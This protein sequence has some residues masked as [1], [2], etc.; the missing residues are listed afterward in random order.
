[1]R[2]RLRAL[3]Q[4]RCGA[5]CGRQRQQRILAKLGIEP[6]PEPPPAPLSRLDLR[7]AK[8]RGPGEAFLDI[9][10]ELR[11]VLCDPAADAPLDLATLQDALVG[12]ALC[13]PAIGI[14]P[15]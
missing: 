14:L 13:Q 1:V 4:R 15:S 7:L 9:G 6:V 2:T 8:R 3:A 11:A 10:S 12:G 5:R